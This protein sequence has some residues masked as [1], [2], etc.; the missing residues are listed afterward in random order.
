MAKKTIKDYVKTIDVYTKDLLASIQHSSVQTVR[1]E[2]RVVQEHADTK[3]ESTRRSLLRTKPGS[4]STLP[5]TL[6]LL[7]CATSGALE[8]SLA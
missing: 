3:V 1:E 6:S 8:H 2:L 7:L 5:L 4:D